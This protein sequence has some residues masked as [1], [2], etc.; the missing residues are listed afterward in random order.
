MNLLIL[1]GKEKRE[2]LKPK[3]DKFFPKRR[4]TNAIGKNTKKIA[5][6]TLIAALLCP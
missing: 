2:M 1:D 6:L 4:N 3:F 5:R